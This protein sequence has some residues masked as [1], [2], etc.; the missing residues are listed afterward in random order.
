MSSMRSLLFVAAFTWMSAPFAQPAN[1]L[2]A[3]KSEVEAL[4]NSQATIIK[5]LQEI[6]GIIREASQPAAPTVPT[7]SVQPSNRNNPP[8]SPSVPEIVDLKLDIGAAPVKGD[9]S[10]KVTVIEFTDY[11]CPFCSR[12]FRQTWPRLEQDFVNTGKARFV[13]RDLPIEQIHPLAFKAAEAAVCAQAQGKFWEMHG[14]LFRNQ[15]AL[16]RKDLSG[17]AKA[18]GL[19]VTAFDKCVDSG[20]NA[21]RIRKDIAD[22][23]AADARGTPI[24]YVGV[25]D[26]KSNQVHVTRIIRG[27]HSYATFKETIDGLLSPS[28]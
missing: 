13:L 6:K 28:N 10:A 16:D 14:Q 19:D 11:Q 9:A 18:V 25:T 3:L 23:R 22:S 26:P 5:E 8:A 27:A 12:H 21:A 7:V 24:F 15:S 20:T 1:D 2:Q 4:K 17:Y